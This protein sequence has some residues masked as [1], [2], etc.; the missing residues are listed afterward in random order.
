M[1]MD[2][3]LDTDEGSHKPDTVCKNTMCF[4]QCPLFHCVSGQDNR[5]SQATGHWPRFHSPRF[6]QMPDRERLFPRNP[7]CPTSTKEKQHS[8]N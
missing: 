3:V 4:V 2:Y 5:V 1:L 8:L 7:F 6:N